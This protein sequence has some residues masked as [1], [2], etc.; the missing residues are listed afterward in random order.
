[1][2]FFICQKALITVFRV[3]YLAFAA[4][5]AFG[6]VGA[7]R[8]KYRTTAT[9]LAAHLLMTATSWTLLFTSKCLWTVLNAAWTL[10]IAVFGCL[11]LWNLYIKRLI[12]KG[13]D[14]DVNFDELW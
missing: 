13:A 11:F 10:I 4:I 14:G 7:W 2:F 12:V 9:F 8:E 3:L 1:M 6:I 5:Q